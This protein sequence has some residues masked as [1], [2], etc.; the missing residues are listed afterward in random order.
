MS[1][2]H[3]PKWF[4]AIFWLIDT[5]DKAITPSRWGE[6]KP[7]ECGKSTRGNCGRLFGPDC[8]ATKSEVG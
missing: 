2:F 4:D 5:A 1:G 7:C 6:N 8:I 3:T